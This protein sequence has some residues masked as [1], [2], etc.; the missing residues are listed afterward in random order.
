MCQA[1]LCSSCVKC[2]TKHPPFLSPMV[3]EP[4]GQDKERLETLPE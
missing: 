3:E 1:S 4:L 2:M